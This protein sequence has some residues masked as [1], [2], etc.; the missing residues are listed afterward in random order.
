[1]T[2]LQLQHAIQS[3]RTVS[4][5][6]RELGLHRNTIYQRLKQVGGIASARPLRR[7]R[8]QFRAVPGWPE[9]RLSR[10]GILQS[11]ATRQ[12]VVGAVWRDLRWLRRT[13]GTGWFAS[14]YRAGVRSRIRL[15]QLLELTYPGEGDTLAAVVVKR[16]E[17]ISRTC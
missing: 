4:E 7:S 17:S 15:Q 14:L 2:P 9:Y 11:R 8:G 1:M 3:G 12:G 10:S 16:L 6:A 13:D 5:L